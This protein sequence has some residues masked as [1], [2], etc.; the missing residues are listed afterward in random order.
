MLLA[1]PDRIAVRRQ[2]GQFQLVNGSQA[3]IP[4]SDA[5]AGSD[6]V[7][8]AD[9]DGHRKSARI[10]LG[11]AVHE[12]DLHRSLGDEL[13]EERSIKW[14]KTRGDIVEH[15]VVRIG[16]LRISERT[17]T[18]PVCDE[19]EEAIFEHLARRKFASVVEADGF[20]RL[21]SRVEFLRRTFPEGDASGDEWPNWSESNLIATAHEWLRPYLAGM[22]SIAEVESMNFE[23]VLRSRLPWSLG[24][25][26][27][28]L[29]PVEL[30]LS[31]GRRLPIDYTEANT[32]DAAP[33][34]DVRVQDLFG[35][36][37][38]PTIASG[39]VPIVLRLLSPA[40]RPIQITSDL[41]GF[42]SGS[43]TDVRKDLAGRYPKHQWP[44][45]PANADPKRLNE[46]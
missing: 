29:A 9:L 15:V 18:A 17:A 41:P 6:Y 32:A 36:R 16:N 10:R 35:T 1:Y 39:R 28:E 8:A 5:L 33:T 25:R 13:H 23:T 22:S 7:V 27:D 34:I 11:L 3:W 20:R 24:S 45:D 12:Q 44:I 42:W 40:D 26:L 19:T 30:Q 21:C 4:T 46:R 37:I 31:S 2:P 38:H 14:D 43:W